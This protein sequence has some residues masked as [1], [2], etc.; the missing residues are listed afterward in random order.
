MNKQSDPLAVLKTVKEELEL[1]VST[2]LIEGCYKLQS[3]HQ[4]DKDRDTLKKM[5]ALVEEK[6]LE[7]EGGKLI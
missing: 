5:K 6:V 2:D 1:T 3:E 4:Y 7:I